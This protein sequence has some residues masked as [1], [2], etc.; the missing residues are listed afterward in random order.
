MVLR[1]TV[2]NTRKRSTLEKWESSLLAC[3]PLH[4]THPVGTKITVGTTI[5]EHSQEGHIFW[6]IALQG[7]HSNWPQPSKAFL[8][9]STGPSKTQ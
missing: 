9:K 7:I 1:F 6:D 3:L 2:L 8:L 5:T 4:L